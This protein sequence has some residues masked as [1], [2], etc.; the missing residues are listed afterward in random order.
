M[1][2]NVRP[3]ELE[4]QQAQRHSDCPQCNPV[5]ESVPETRTCPYC[6]SEEIPYEDEAC[7]LC[8]RSLEE[9]RAWYQERAERLGEQRGE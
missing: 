7:E 1:Q 6:I 9:M 2:K 4:S 8:E 5:E 3:Q